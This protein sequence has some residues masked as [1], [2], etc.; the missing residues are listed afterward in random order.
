MQYRLY[1]YNIFLIR[2]IILFMVS[3]YYLCF[4]LS[5]NN[6]IF[7]LNVLINQQNNAKIEF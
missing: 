3:T 2:N 4:R 6:I 5:K 7:Y 1:I